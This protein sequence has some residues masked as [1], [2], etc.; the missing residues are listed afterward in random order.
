MII[1]GRDRRQDGSPAL[2]QAQ[3]FDLE[4]IKRQY[5]NMMDIMTYDDLL[6]RLGII[7]A[8]LDRR[9][10]EAGD[11]KRTRPPSAD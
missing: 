1:L 11:K 4:V 6:R 8:S 5:A 2:D 9:V 3:L 7:I 10:K